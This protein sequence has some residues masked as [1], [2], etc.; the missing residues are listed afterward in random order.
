[1]IVEVH[2]EKLSDGSRSQF[3]PGST[4]DQGLLLVHLEVIPEVVVAVDL[5]WDNGEAF[6]LN[7]FSPVVVVV[8][9]VGDCGEA[10]CLSCNHSGSGRL[11][12]S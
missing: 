9:L 8:D 1:M 12:T 6:L 5:V 11:S 2:E 7:L 4:L 3:F 10:F